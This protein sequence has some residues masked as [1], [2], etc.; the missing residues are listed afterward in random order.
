MAFGDRRAAQLFVGLAEV[1]E[2]LALTDL[3]AAYDAGGGGFHGEAGGGDVAE[4]LVL[5]RQG[6][7]L[8]LAVQGGTADPCREVAPVL[9]GVIGQAALWGQGAAMWKPAAMSLSLASITRA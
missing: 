4:L 3:G 9:A 1:E 5:V 2:D 6:A 8:D 7:A